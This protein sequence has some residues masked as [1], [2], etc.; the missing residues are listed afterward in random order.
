[1]QRAVG[2]AHGLPD[3]RQKEVVERELFG[4]EDLVLDVVFPQT[5]EA[6][7]AEGAFELVADVPEGVEPFP[8][9]HLDL[10][11]RAHARGGHGVEHAGLAHDERHVELGGHQGVF[12]DGQIV[13]RG[14][15][16]E[17]ESLMRARER[18]LD[19]APDAMDLDGHFGTIERAKERVDLLGRKGDRIIVRRFERDAG[20][21]PGGDHL[22]GS[23][24]HDA[25]RDDAGELHIGFDAGFLL[26]LF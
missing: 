12:A 26:C 1:M 7:G 17:E 22:A 11:E 5:H 3:A 21:L 8:E 18:V 4:A 20:H 9:F 16:V 23:A 2:N 10:V 15:I 14:Q 6:V 25:G 24:H 19:V 13:V